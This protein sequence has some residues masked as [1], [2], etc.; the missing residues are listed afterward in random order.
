MARTG[1]RQ[2][3]LRDLAKCPTGIQGLDEI[4][5][6]GVPRGRPTLV[7][8]A[9]G[10]GKTL[11]TMEFLV[12]GITQ[13]GEPGVFVSFEETAEELMHNVASLGFDLPRLIRRK[14]L[15]LDYVRVER[16]EIEETGE[17]DLEGLFVRMAAA[18]DAVGAKRVVIDSIEALFGGLSNEGILRAELRRLFR[19]LKDKGVTAI[20]TGEQGEGT[21]TR[22]GL[23]EYVSDCVIVLD[24]RVVKQIATR[25]LRI[26]KYRGSAHG[27]NEYPTLIDAHGLWVLPISSL[28]LTYPVSAKRI[29]SGVPRLD[30]MLGGQGY[31]QGSSILISGTAG[32]GKTSLAVAFADNVCRQGGGVLYCAF[33]E[34]PDQIL[35]NM[36]SIGYHLDR[37][38]QAG[39]LHFHAV[40]P[41]AYGLELHLATLHKQIQ[42][43]HPAALVLDPISN[44]MAVGDPEET[45]AMLTRLIDFAK[46]QGIT[47]LLTSLTEGGGGLERTGEGISSLMDTWLLARM[48][49]TNGERNRLLYILKSRGMDHSNQMREF[50]LTPQGIRLQDVYVGPGAVF[51]GTARLVQEAQD[52]AAALTA[53]QA[54]ERRARDLA[55]EQASLEAQ[56]AALTARVTTLQS[57]RE[58]LEEQELRR[59]ETLRTDAGAL[60]TAR[61]AD[62]RK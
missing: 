56:V 4:T 58:T 8:G 39:R 3:V 45:R 57:E 16:S 53:R 7:C 10:S 34:A 52:K 55:Q 11:L 46:F 61:Q 37:W 49:E 24:H 38:R 50:L 22:H 23:E 35:R 30:A 19:W 48:L 31:F 33:E 18:I 41:T 44:L 13:Y 26:V 60:T 25:R 21:L 2:Q 40:R 9:A 32:T 14:R 47:A 51:T 42:T 54:A 36:R 5:Q 59:R 1:R 15:A 17:Y 12:R 29:S 62:P 6:G 27:T 20:V 43:V 28:S